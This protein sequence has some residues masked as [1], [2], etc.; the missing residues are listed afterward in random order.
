MNKKI[1]FVSWIFLTC[2]WLHICVK[3]KLETKDDFILFLLFLRLFW[4]LPTTPQGL[5]CESWKPVYLNLCALLSFVGFT[6][7]TVER[8]PSVA[9]KCAW[10]ICTRFLAAV[11][12]RFHRYDRRLSDTFQ[13]ARFKNTLPPQCSCWLLPHF[14]AYRW[15]DGF[16]EHLIKLVYFKSN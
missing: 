6:H 10:G 7:M 8:Q 5:P 16:Y 4:P 14:F 13:S 9:G 12:E 3:N 11:G 15:M 1:P 2:L